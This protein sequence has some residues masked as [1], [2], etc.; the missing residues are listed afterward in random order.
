MPARR[1][2]GAASA[3]PGESRRGGRP[4]LLAFRASRADGG[5]GADLELALAHQGDASQRR[6]PRPFTPPV[7]AGGA[8]AADRRAEGPPA[9][10]RRP[11]ARR[12]VAE[13]RERGP[14]RRRDELK[15]GGEAAARRPAADRPPEKP[16]GREAD[17]S[18]LAD[19]TVL[20]AGSSRPGRYGR[21]SDRLRYGVT[22]IARSTVGDSSPRGAP[23]VGA[24]VALVE[25]DGQRDGSSRTESAAPA[26]SPRR[27][28]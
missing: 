4:G 26:A 10:W 18:D 6:G 23:P 16:L 25:R 12:S 24:A 7:A 19:V 2:R 13:E 8:P 15:P 22:T 21:Q 3:A 20:A 1:R 28:T 5:A 14:A 17:D 11:S 27:V 9:S